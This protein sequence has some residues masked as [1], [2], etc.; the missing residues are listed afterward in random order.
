MIFNDLEKI[1]TACQLFLA[2][3]AITVG[4]IYTKSVLVP[5][6]FAIFI[7][8]LATPI[9][10]VLE[11]YTPLPRSL[12][13]TF[14]IGLFLVA[15]ALVVFFV[16]SSIQE[17]F[18]GAEKYQNRVIDFLNWI[19]SQLE[20]RDQ[21]VESIREGLSMLQESVAQVP[22]NSVAVNLTNMMLTFLANFVLV[23]IMALFL[24]VGGTQ[25]DISH[26]LY[27]KIQFS[28]S[29]Y[30][31]LKFLISI[32]TGVLTF[33]VLQFFQ[34]ELA[35][36]FAVLTFLLNFIP[37]LGSVVAVLL[38]IPL[39]IL[40]FE[41]TAPLFIVLGLLIAL[42]FVIGNVIEPELMGDKMGLHPVTVL[43][44]LIFWGLVWD[45]A[46]LFL[47][48]P[49]TAVVRII[50]ARIEMTRPIAELLAG[51]LPGWRS[52]SDENP[53]LEAPD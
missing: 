15:S 40:Q 3:V 41:F 27:R 20:G 45:I 52:G 43:L 8:F 7:Y 30:I 10:N 44:C 16:V 12:A 17:F 47:A 46:G 42:Q 24:I 31:S 9:V 13:A 48:V 53:A 39:L 25:Q 22:V 37:T 51:H 36:M 21:E 14:A 5:L 11:E 4:L 29:R 1:K 50:L 19:A 2:A 38:P 35:L 26:E 32:V 33:A 34:V 28:I 6:V 18:Q 49:I 23:I